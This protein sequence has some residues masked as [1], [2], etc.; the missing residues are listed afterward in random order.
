MAD[1]NTLIVRLRIGF[2]YIIAF[3]LLILVP[4]LFMNMTPQNIEKLGKKIPIREGTF[5]SRDG[6]LAPDK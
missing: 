4:L 1:K 6:G 3:V 2:M 5:E